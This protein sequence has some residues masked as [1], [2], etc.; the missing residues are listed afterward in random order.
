MTDPREIP[1]LMDATSVKAILDGS[2]IQTR[3]PVKPQPPPKSQWHQKARLFRL[4]GSKLGVIRRC[5]FGAPDDLLWV[6]ETWAYLLQ[7]GGSKRYMY[8]DD[9]YDKTLV[10]WW[11]EKWHPSIHMPRAACRITLRVKRVWAHKV[12]EIDLDDIVAE[13]YLDNKQQVSTMLHQSTY[14]RTHAQFDW[15]IKYWNSIYAKKNLGM[16]HNPWVW[17]CEFE[18]IGT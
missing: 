17:A 18:R 12:Q 8:R 3:R 9:P 16:S 10:Q 6:R 11:N 5:P 1:I 13:G 7:T 4:E 14:H 2:K 15:F